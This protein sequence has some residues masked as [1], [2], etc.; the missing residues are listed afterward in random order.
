M[1][2]HRKGKGHIAA[3][4]N[5]R[6]LQCKTLCLYTAGIG[7]PKDIQHIPVSL[8]K[9]RP[10]AMIYNPVRIPVVTVPFL[11]NVRNQARMRLG[12]VVQVISHAFTDIERRI[13]FQPL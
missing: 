3:N 6:R 2:L 7:K 12:N 9:Q 13:C 10:A 1:G 8:F 11:C 5:R 4:A